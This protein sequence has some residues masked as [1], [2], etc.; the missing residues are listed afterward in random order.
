MIIG[1]TE[2]AGEMV[3]A[4]VLFWYVFQLSSQPKG[5]SIYLFDYFR[6]KAVKN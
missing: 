3:V 6:V 5:N 2:D 4:S 1:F